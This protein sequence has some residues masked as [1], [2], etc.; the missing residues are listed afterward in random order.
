MST[1]IDERVLEM[2]FDN[3]QFESNV[4]TTM[5]T[6]DKLKQK[7]NLSGA[8]KGLEDVGAA[9]RKVDLSPIG[10]S[11]Q[12]VGLK[13][14]AMYT[15]ADQAL[16]DITNSAMYYGKKIINALTIDPV[17]TGF[18]EYELKMNSV[19]TIMASTGE[20]IDTVNKYLQELNEYSDQTIYSFSDM[21]QNIGKFT[22]AGVKLEDAVAAI[23]GISNEAALSGA[24][25]NEASRAMYNFSQALSAGYVKLIDWKSIENANMATKSFKEELIKTAVE[26]G[27]VTETSDGMYKTLEGNVFNATKNFNE[28]L[29]DQ[30]M[31]SDVLITTLKKYSDETTEIGKNAS[32][33]ATKVKT[34]SQ[35]WDTLK[36]ASQSG[37]ASTWET[38]IGDLEE[39]KEL[40][41][42]IS[43]VVGGFIDRTSD[44]RNTLVSGVLDFQPFANLRDLFSGTMFEKVEEYAEKVSNLA[45]M[46]E[47]Y[48]T[49]V[50]KVWQGDY[51]NRG[52]NPDRFDLLRG[53]GYDPSVVQELVNLGYKHELTVEDLEAAYAKW[54]K[55]AEETAKSTEKV[56]LNLEHLSDAEL[57]NIGLTELEIKL[58]RYLEQVARDTGKSLSEVLNEM[59]DMTIRDMMIDSFKAIGRVIGEVA[60]AIGKA[61][62]TIFNPEGL[63][64]DEKM[65]NRIVGLQTALTEFYLFA[66]NLKL[67]DETADK[68]ART[69]Q[70]LFAVLDIITSI[71]GGGFKIAF[72][73]LSEILS[74]FNVD[75]LWLTANIGDALVAFHDW[76]FS[77]VDIHAILDV[78]VPWIKEA[79]N[80]IKEL[81]K[82]AKDSK[83][84]GAFCDNLAKAYEAVK[85]WIMGTRTL[86]ISAIFNNIIA[87][88]KGF[89]KAVLDLVKSIPGMSGWIDRLVGMFSSMRNAFSDWI[90][91][92]KTTD[93]IPKYIL[94][95]LIIGLK[96]G[97]SAVWDAATNLARVLVDAIKDFLGIHSPSTAFILIGGFIIAGLIKGL[98]GGFGDVWGTLVGIG[99]K[100]IDAIGSIDILGTISSIVS[101]SFNG[102]KG[103]VA[104]LWDLLVSVASKLVEF[105][106]TLDLGTLMAGAITAGFIYTG[107][108]VAKAVENFSKPFG[109]VGDFLDNIGEAAQRLSKSFSNYLNSKALLNIAYAIGILALSLVALTFVNVGK[110]WSAV[111]AIVVISGVLAAL[112]VVMNKLD[113]DEAKLK[114]KIK[115]ITAIA[116]LAAALLLVAIAVRIIAGIGSGIWQAVGIIGGFIVIA[117][118][119]AAFGDQLAGSSM[120]TISKSLMLMGAAFAA[121][122]VAVK[123]ASTIDQAGF[124][125]AVRVLGALLISIGLLTLIT[126]LGSEKNMDNASK[127]ILKM[128]AAM[129]L[130][131][132]TAKMAGKVDETAFSRM[133]NVISYF[134]LVI[135][136]LVLITHLDSGNNMETASKFILMAG[137]AM[138][139]LA[140][141]AKIAGR[142]S[143]EEFMMATEVISYFA[144][145]IA[146]LVLFTRL[147]SDKELKG[148]ALTLLAASIAIGIMAAI[149]TLLSLVSFD[150]LK[151]GLKAVG[152]LAAII[153]GMTAVTYFAKDAKGTLVGIAIAIGILVASLVMLSFIAKTNADGLAGATAAI[154][155]IL[156]LLATTLYS[157]KNVQ[158]S[159]GVLIVLTVAIG[160]LSTALYLLAKLPVK[161]TLGASAALAIVLGAMIGALKLLDKTQLRIF[162]VLENIIALTAL[163]VPLM[164]FAKA[165]VKMNGLEGAITKAIAL[166]GLT[167]V[168]VLLLK[169]LAAV[170]N[171]TMAAIKG[172]IALAVVSAS[173][174]VLVGVLHAMKGVENAVTNALILSGLAAILTYVIIPPLTTLGKKGTAAIKGA[175]ALAIV[176]ASLLV[177]VGVLH[178]M[179]GVQNAMKNAGALILLATAL[180]LLLIPLTLVGTLGSSAYVG[181]GALATIALALLVLV[182]VLAV[183]NNV[184]NAMQN[185]LVLAGLATVLT[186]L[187]IP[188]TAIGLLGPAA[189][190]G[191]VALTAMAVP[192]LAFIGTLAL[193]NSVQNATANAMLLIGLMTIMSDILIK[194]SVIAPLALVGV[195]AMS[196]LG[197]FMIAI[198]TLAVAV[199]ALMT[200]F[201]ALQ[202]FLDVGIPVLERL[203]YSIGSI[204]GNLVAGFADGALSSLPQIGLYLSEFMANVTGFIEGA[205]SIDES[206][207]AGVGYL[208]AAVVA[209]TAADLIEGIVSFVSGGNSF[210][211]LGTELSN[212]MN[213]AK[214][215]ID[216]ASMIDEDMVSGVKMIADTILIL[217]AANVLEGLASWVT[218]SGSIESFATQFP[219]L[220]QGLAGFKDA[221]GESGFTADDCLVVENA[222]NAVKTLASAASEIPNSG[223]WVGAI[224]GENDLDKFASQFPKLGEGLKSFKDALGEGGF[225]T[226]DCSIVENAAN[227]VKTLA[228]AASEIPNSGGWVAKIVGDNDLAAF[229]SQF[230]KLGYG[231]SAFKSAI[232]A[233]EFSEA[234][235]GAVDAAANAVKKFSEVAQDIPNSGG[236]VAKI[237]GD[238]DLES[239]ANKFPAVGTGLA[240]LRT[241][242]GSWT[243]KDGLMVLSVVSAISYLADLAT[244]INKD[245]SVWDALT[246]D[247]MTFVSKLPA[248]ASYMQSFKNNLGSGFTVE[249]AQTVSNIA[250]AIKTFSQTSFDETNWSS[251][252]SSSYYLPTIGS[253]MAQFTT[254]LA[255]IEPNDLVLSKTASNT[256]LTIIKNISN[257]L[258]DSAKLKSE[259]MKLIG[260]DL[261][262]AVTSFA[263]I[264]RISDRAEQSIAALVSLVEGMVGLDVSG[265]TALGDALKKLASDSVA[266]FAN[267]FSD[268][269]T[270]ERIKGGVTTLVSTAATEV[271]N[272]AAVFTTAV[273]KLVTDGA[274]TVGNETQYRKFYAAG[275]YLVDGFA[276]GISANT[277][278]AAAKSAAMAEAAVN[279][280]RRV[281][282]EHSP[283]KVFYNIGDFA[284]IGFVNALTDHVGTSYDAAFDMA[285]SAK[286]GLSDAIDKIRKMIDSGMDTQPTIKPVLDLSDVRSGVGAMNNLLSMG[287]SRTVLANVG[288]IN[289]TMNRRSQNAGNDDIVSAIDKLRGELGNVGN[290][291]YNINGLSYKD[292]AELDAAFKTI[293]RAVTVGR[294]V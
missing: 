11:A 282:D 206:V 136:A 51:N 103:L 256:I 148:V 197:A 82:S 166:S 217:T 39:A 96:N 285:S 250:E 200:N 59:A 92:F 72:K 247:F 163:T 236:W 272:N 189:F 276:S 266:K 135:T 279:A 113:G 290:T 49:V 175:A 158:S 180:T 25:A 9:A 240:G 98:T 269:S 100:V 63:T 36:E 131:M 186:A 76:L 210:A 57:K 133:T 211:A 68:L 137:A 214:L 181:V 15:M 34:F 258:I 120:E 122:A 239:F 70:G 167:T 111:G 67:S 56:T 213:N 24:N 18:S 112:M 223:G 117:G 84:F 20:S 203:A 12:T 151:D 192:M 257:A 45:D 198:G 222:A 109:Q 204:A 165:L 194:V 86:D 85:G 193:M 196:A 54:G 7:L 87:S 178:A 46:L 94:E 29:Q 278:K 43:K 293:V 132:L 287:T 190:V 71:L 209:L 88:V 224:V 201:P 265:V 277:Y 142:M 262:N 6:L 52:D 2:R 182:G 274:S 243:D 116:G 150:K 286:S 47:Y 288:A 115:V 14:N 81:F 17:K 83:V 246:D 48:Q 107:I 215:F 172:A 252:V 97:I 212:F 65:T 95:G 145:V 220:G 161:N 191:V 284:G 62:Q 143:K 144:L 242:I 19:Q 21:T 273:E 226:E 3:K 219:L 91:G 10:D 216:G 289:S 162:S 177:L 169:P 292:D 187:L 128:G 156:A 218:G 106:K 271:E 244:Q 80:W 231:L 235:L 130:L 170:G 238:N 225:T 35:L 114:N 64:G 40:L 164:R 69:F 205:R 294:R 185:A 179:K 78:V 127:F 129:L 125:N 93:N 264:G 249:V 268:R 237:I 251:L 32:E 60:S 154:A 160:I 263:D 228:A 267:A 5:S 99:Q 208:S 30:W 149:A 184:Q 124:D 101:T 41:T 259:T 74:Y 28:V 227:A 110:L 118:L 8:S 126:H 16:R 171:D 140:L 168:M 38:I 141:T 58:L 283:S 1:T 66:M 230:P 281:L 61:W 245:T 105:V 183:M 157:S 134:A 253:L 202:Q 119:L 233:S 79:A 199:G 260:S 229:A 275:S 188:L 221:L 248:L 147:A 153:A 155:V 255:G 280:A 261:L 89:G 232:S 75:I 55:A 270:E 108:K 234:D 121:I 241:N 195:T 53:E 73:V 37:W 102:A 23:K 33:A 291:N 31:T 207:L 50:S 44:W 123:I 77:L 159:M 104:T 27:M 173:L 174:F 4:S 152:I 176:S 22:N 26:L 42:D 146:G 90:A 13:F 254:A 138:L 139:L